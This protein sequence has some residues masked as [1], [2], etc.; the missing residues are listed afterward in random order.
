MSR[1]QPEQAFVVWFKQRKL[2]L[3]L[4]R[5]SFPVDLGP[6]AVSTVAKRFTSVRMNASNSSGIDGVGVAPAG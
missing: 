3:K 5:A 4:R 6:A 2:Q 1:E